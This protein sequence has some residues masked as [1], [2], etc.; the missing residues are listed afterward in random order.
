LRAMTVGISLTMTDKKPQPNPKKLRHGKATVTVWFR[1]DDEKNPNPSQW[2]AGILDMVEDS[3]NV[4][5]VSVRKLESYN[6]DT[7]KWEKVDTK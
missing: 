7:D 1:Y 5:D 2:L 4:E 6:V 3:D